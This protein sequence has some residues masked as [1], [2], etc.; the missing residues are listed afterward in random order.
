MET[1][2]LVF[3]M[4]SSELLVITF[5]DRSIKMFAKSEEVSKYYIYTLYCNIFKD[6]LV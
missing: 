6:V 4:I 5:K 3:H 1:L 2:L